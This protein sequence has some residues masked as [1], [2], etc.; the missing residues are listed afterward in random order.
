MLG[1][2]DVEG[3]ELVEVIEAKEPEEKSN[4]EEG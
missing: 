2:V 4:Q 3:E 1:L